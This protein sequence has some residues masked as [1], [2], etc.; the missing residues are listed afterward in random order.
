MSSEFIG[1]EQM[2][3]QQDIVYA[4]RYML[5]RE[6]ENAAIVTENRMD[7]QTLRS[8]FAESPEYIL[9]HDNLLKMD[10]LTTQKVIERLKI[11]MDYETVL[12]NG[13]SKLIHQGDTV[14]DIGAHIGRHLE[15]FNNLVGSQGNL[16]AFEPLPKQFDYL[17]KKFTR[18]NVNLFNIA[19]SNFSGEENFCKVVNYPE[20]SGLKQRIYNNKDAVVKHINVQVRQLDDFKDKFDRVDYIKIDAEG[21][22]YAILQGGNSTIE[23]FRPIISTEY[24]YPSYSVYGV[25]KRSLYYFCEL[26]N[27]MITD[28]FGNLIPTLNMWD[29]LCDSVYWD[30]FL[31]PNEKIT[32]FLLAL[33]KF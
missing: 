23:K 16:V 31:V 15:V 6:P 13:Y 17:L 11:R 26:N 4:Y 7:W 22:E 30:Y 28:I 24:G 2:D 27:Y 9:K 20:E 33:H 21:A 19:L 8:V 12:E 25:Q 32:E 14:I 5:G 29:K 3:L 10:A 18:N 1:T